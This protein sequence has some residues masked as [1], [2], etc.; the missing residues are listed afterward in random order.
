MLEQGHE[1]MCQDFIGPVS[2]KDL[3]RCQQE[4]RKMVGDCLFQSI[5]V[6]IRV[7]AQRCA[8]DPD[9]L[10]HCGNGQRRRRVGVLV[11][12]QFD[13]IGKLR[14]FSRSVGVRL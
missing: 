13:Q 2:D 10:L 5:G 3:C 14:L 9:L 8:V 4:L 6:R 12:V 1:G 11:G 7:Q